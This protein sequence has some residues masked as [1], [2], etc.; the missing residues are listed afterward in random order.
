MKMA[1]YNRLILYLIS[2]GF[3]TVPALSAEL[4]RLG[5]GFKRTITPRAV[6]QRKTHGP[7]LQQAL[8][9][10]GH[11]RKIV[12]D[13]AT[14]RWRLMDR[15]TYH[16]PESMDSLISKYS[17]TIPKNVDRRILLL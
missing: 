6:C 4:Q 9:Y 1:I 17:K 2:E 3:D 14:G 10:L 13:K 5:V 12:A 8:K 15:N 7:P 11:N 16:P